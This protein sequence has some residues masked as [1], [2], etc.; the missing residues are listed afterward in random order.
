M[1]DSTDKTSELDQYG[2]W[3]KKPPR[4]ISDAPD[5]GDELDLPDFSFLD[6]QAKESVKIDEMDNPAEEEV[7]LDDFLDSESEE[8]AETPQEPAFSE[9]EG[10]TRD[11]PDGEADA[12]PSAEA[13]AARS[14][15]D[16]SLGDFLD[17]EQDSPAT[18]ADT[19]DDAPLDIDL[20]FDDGSTEEAGRSSASEEE[21]DIS[22][23]DGPASGSEG[24]GT[25]VDLENFDDMFSTITDESSRDATEEVDLS[26]FGVDF[27]EDSA[28]VQAPAASE[29]AVSDFNVDTDAES[30][31]PSDVFSSENS[32]EYDL[33]ISITDSAGT[34]EADAAPAFEQRQVSDDDDF[35]FDSIL[36]NVTDENGETVAVGEDSA[37]ADAMDSVEDPT[38]LDLQESSGTAQEDGTAEEPDVVDSADP[39]AEDEIPDTVSEEELSDPEFDIEPDVSSLNEET[40]AQLDEEPSVAEDAPLEEP[41]DEAEAEPT[42]EAPRPA[43]EYVP[44]AS[45]AGATNSILQQ[46]AAELSS[47]RGEITT[48]KQDFANLKEGI[49][50]ESVSKNEDGGGFFG[51]DDDDEAIA[52]SGNELDNILSNAEVT[53]SDSPETDTAGA[54]AMEGTEQSDGDIA[55]APIPE[56][57]EDGGFFGGGDDDE[58]IAL[59]G[60]ELDNIL[61]SADITLSEETGSNEAIDDMFGSP[62]D[63]DIPETNDTDEAQNRLTM[64]FSSSDG[65]EE[66][67][68]DTIDTYTEEPAEQSHEEPETAS[69]DILVDSSSSDLMEV[70]AVAEQAEELLPEEGPSA[71][72]EPADIEEAEAAGL[73]D[74]DLFI[75]EPAEPEV[76]EENKS[77]G[78]LSDDS[79]DFLSEDKNVIL[80]DQMQAASVQDDI[81][82]DLKKEIKT[83]LAYMDQLLESLPEEK[84]TEFAKSEQFETYK[85]LFNELGLA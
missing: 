23:F 37:V 55:D 62:E 75:D 22:S 18:P 36:S 10:A 11:E 12:V 21:I 65:I 41:A 30:T 33:D 34:D 76:I 25:T 35:D 71:A 67:S 29:D 26:D 5:A 45:D 20:S 81:P 39:I 13:P 27:S 78:T 84:I 7:S 58:A 43:P 17:E 8:P 68:L 51:D 38:S 16:V 24:S 54:A 50:T 74:E 53:V 40:R 52:L 49:S 15:G 83:V 3:V 63:V 66:P 77:D 14:D 28:Q 48:L 80:A 44:P 61:N 4:S 73:S 31:V 85:K 82:S 19:G 70:P 47:L 6:E 60:N 79:L 9:D 56:A 59:S 46:I 72:G 69:D 32:S 64:D 57:E 2:V 42:D 1:A